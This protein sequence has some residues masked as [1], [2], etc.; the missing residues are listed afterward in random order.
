MSFS[1]LFNLLF[2]SSLL[3]SCWAG[4]FF[5]LLSIVSL[6]GRWTNEEHALFLQGLQQY[7]KQWKLIADLVKSRTVVQIRTHAQKYFL[8]LHK[9]KQID[10]KNYALVN[11]IVVFVS[12]R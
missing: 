9:S 10:D 6:A 4:S 1:F 7:S 8:K 11:D 5:L 3:I 12:F 2:L